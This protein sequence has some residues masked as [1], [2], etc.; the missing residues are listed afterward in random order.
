MQAR[1]RASVP[2][3]TFQLWL[4]PLKVVGSRS[5]TLLLSAP[6][7]IRA[8][9]ERRYAGLIREALSGAGSQLTN[10]SLVVE[11][12]ARSWS[13]ARGRARAQRQLHL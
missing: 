13:W 5:E 1:L 8:W 4:E 9:T 12:D 2:A 11:G 6:E 7:G 10:V 3:S